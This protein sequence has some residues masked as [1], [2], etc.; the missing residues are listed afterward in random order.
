MEGLRHS[1]VYNSPFF[2]ENKKYVCTA[3]PNSGEFILQRVVSNVQN[4][5]FFLFFFSSTALNIPNVDSFL[6]YFVGL[7]FRNIGVGG[8]VCLFAKL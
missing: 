5:I 1:K 4:F 6:F 8:F 2:S 7:C 3:N